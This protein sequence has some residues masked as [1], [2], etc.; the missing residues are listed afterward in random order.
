VADLGE[1]KAIEDTPY[2]NDND[3]SG[4]DDTDSIENLTRENSVIIK[5]GDG[6]QFD[7]AATH[8]NPETTVT[9]EWL[10]DDHSMEQTDSDLDFE[11]VLIQNERD[12]HQW[13]FD[14]PGV[15][16]YQC[17]PHAVQ[18]DHGAIIIER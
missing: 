16:L 5:T 9:C 6:L 12:T 2:L 1:S 14:E 15:L 18:G 3:A 13:R 8:I 11:D 10:S 7:P 4:Y 17:G